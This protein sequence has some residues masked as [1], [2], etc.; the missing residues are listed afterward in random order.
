MDN[1][2]LEI[3]KPF[4]TRFF[5]E[6]MR[7]VKISYKPFSLKTENSDYCNKKEE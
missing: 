4:L 1:E 7:H 3:R 5:E 2:N 6:V